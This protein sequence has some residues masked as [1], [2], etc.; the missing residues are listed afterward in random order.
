MVK[1]GKFYI[2]SMTKEEE[3]QLIAFIN[4]GVKFAKVENYSD[5]MAE[6]NKALEIDPT[7]FIVL[8]Y[9]G[10]VFYL[11]GNHFGQE[12]VAKQ[13]LKYYPDK[14]EAYKQ[15]SMCYHKIGRI[16]EGVDILKIAVQKYPK[17]PVLVPNLLF[18]SNS[19][20][21][22]MDEIFELHCKFAA[23]YEPKPALPKPAFRK[24]KKIKVGFVSSDFFAHS[25]YYFLF[26]L[27]LSY[28]KE[29][30]EF[31]LLSN[32]NHSHFDVITEAL[33]S[34]VDFWHDI[35]KLSDKEAAKLIR[36]EE[37]SVL[38]DLNGYTTAPVR[39]GIFG[40]RPAPVQISWL[41]YPNTTG[42]KSMDFRITDNYADSLEADK[43]YTEK[44][45]RF[46]TPFLCFFPSIGARSVE[47]G[48]VEKTE[49]E[50]LIFGSF[51]NTTKIT[52]ETISLWCAVLK[53]VPNSRMVLKS[54]AFNDPKMYNF[55]LGKFTSA[56][57][58]KERIEIKG[59]SPSEKEH[60]VE[61][62]K[63]DIA[64]DT[65]PYNGTTT[66]CEAMFMGVPTIALMGE[67]HVA[68]VS[69]A[70]NLQAGFAEFV[71][72]T[73]EEFAEIAEYWAAHKKEL[74][75]YKNSMRERMLASPLCNTKNFT[76]EWEKVIGSLVSNS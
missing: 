40:L 31:H 51:N 6:L 23:N 60:L 18:Y 64:L 56:G 67:S 57:I 71:A 3:K 16:K 70:L 58:E 32:T 15:F 9:I 27:F 12:L 29:R 39:L 53:K 59:H 25:V 30:F 72:K 41:G 66:T 61:Y 54:K 35:T 68:R 20:M 46:K 7:N 17:D 2:T 44:L 75:E 8:S 43:Y 52:D 63:I 50:A 62:L 5:A 22:P 76:S 21:I 49:D 24:T 33:K 55:Y 74:C 28:N 48:F 36:K 13:L 34:F 19:L 65:I 26:S 38:F 69:A 11:T 37:I 10:T 45:L 1:N 42:M 47:A 73:E 4:A 14:T